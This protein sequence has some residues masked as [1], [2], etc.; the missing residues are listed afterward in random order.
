M[1][2]AEIYGN[3]NDNKLLKSLSSSGKTM[4]IDFKIPDD[5][6]TS[7]FIKFTTL[8]KYKKINHDCQT[9]LDINTN[10]LMSPYHPNKTNCSWVITTNSRSHIILDFKYIEVNFLILINFS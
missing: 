8:I 4:F 3:P 1:K 6:W 5:W 7:V 2:I 10:T 9:W